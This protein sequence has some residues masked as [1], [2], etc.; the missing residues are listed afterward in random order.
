MLHRIQLKKLLL[1]NWRPKLLS[2]ICA[3]VV[4]LMVNHLLVRG[5]SAE[6]DIDDIR[7][8]LPE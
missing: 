3:V 1:N 2:L 8:V 5:D 6:W 7:V 4:W